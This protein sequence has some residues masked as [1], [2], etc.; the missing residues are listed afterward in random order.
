MRS[1]PDLRI[2]EGN[3]APVRP[4]GD[5]V[6]YWMTSARRTGWNFALQRARDWAEE[7]ERPLLVLEALRVDYRY[8]SDR[9]HSFVLQGMADN[10]RALLAAPAHYLAYVEPSPGAGK[11]LLATL[12]TRACVVVGD[13]YPAFFLPRM[14]AAAGRAVDVRLEL[15]DGNGL[16]P[17]HAASRAFTRAHDFRRFLQRQLPLHLDAVPEANPLATL[18][19]AGPAPL[20]TAL[21]EYWPAPPDALLAADP[22]ALA[23]LPIDHQVPPSRIRGGA[24]AGR[25]TLEKFFAGGIDHYGQHNHPDADATSGL[26]PYLHFGHVGA[27]QVFAALAAHEEWNPSRTADRA[28]GSREGWWGMSATAEAFVDQLV[29]WRELGFN[30]CANLPDCDR[31]ASLPE[32]ARRT[33]AEHAGDERPEL[34]DDDALEQAH[35]G[36]ELWNAAQRELLVDGRIHNYL[37]MLWGKKLL[38]WSATPEQALA[39]M[40]HLNDKYALDGRDPNSLSGIFW[41]LGRYDRAWGPERP[42]F[43]KIRY[44]TSASARRK[45][46]LRD[47][48]E[49]WASPATSDPAGC[50]EAAS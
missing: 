29:T 11:G 25:Q 14:L 23:R 17:V 12:A 9:L 6:L 47:Y 44:M 45:L 36:D 49:R 32:W 37:R 13:D 21:R 50:R 1:F 18:S 46:R 40:L 43:G 42:I 2:R 8:A 34:Y 20:P 39:R 5:Y 27:H 24:E 10:A 48:L 4:D 3:G 35:T 30:G 19:D 33:L 16:L 38:E 41:V 22:A 7:L 15:I 26:S 28:N 31:Y